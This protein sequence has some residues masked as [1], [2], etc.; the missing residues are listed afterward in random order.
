MDSFPPKVA[1][2]Q[3]VKP[4]LNYG[5]LRKKTTQKVC[6]ITMATIYLGGVYKVYKFLNTRQ[7]NSVVKD[8]LC[9]NAIPFQNS[10]HFHDA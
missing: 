1:K 3:F 10:P 2:M 4:S 7:I 8:P 6:S 5:G 9:A